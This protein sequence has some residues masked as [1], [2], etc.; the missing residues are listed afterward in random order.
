M[1]LREKKSQRKP[2]ILQSIHHTMEVIGNP[3]RVEIDEKA[4]FETSQLQVSNHLSIV[5]ILQFGHSLE[6]NEN[7]IIHNKVCSETL[8]ELLTIPY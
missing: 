7:L 8:T 6:F 4:K 2:L 3:L 1:S 5:N